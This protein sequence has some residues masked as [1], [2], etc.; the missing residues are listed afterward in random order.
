MLLCD[1]CDAGFHSSCVGL[2]CVPHGSW[3][4]PICLDEPDV[5]DLL[6]H[7]M[8]K[9]SSAAAVAPPLSSVASGSPPG[10][11]DGS[12]NL[13]PLYDGCFSSTSSGVTSPVAPVQQPSPPPSPSP[14][15]SPPLGPRIRN[16][17]E[18]FDPSAYTASTPDPDY[19]A[20]AAA[21]AAKRIA[22]FIVTDHDPSN[23][24]DALS[25]PD[26]DKWQAAMD[27]ELAS[28]L[29]NDT[30]TVTTLPPGAR[31]IPTKWVFAL[32]RGADG[33][34]QR[35][36]ARLVT[37]GFRQ[38]P[39]IDFNELYSP[40]AKSATLRVFL[41]YVAEHDFAL[42]TCDVKTAFLNANLDETIYVTP[43]PGYPEP[44]GTVC[45]LSKSLYGLRQSPRQWHLRL[46][47]ELASLGF[48]PASADASLFIRGSGKTLTFCLT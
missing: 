2:D 5:T 1:T 43:P 15:P 41:A 18:R 45:L 25:R 37:Q 35:Y 24:T 6:F 28:L 9:N 31:A 8:R 7:N 44:P 27:D 23:H 40:V 36:K 39:G 4:C 26:A 17:P 48:F 14:T 22:P 12:P 30:W 38:R 10:S 3:H 13:N 19:V 46:S 16:Q 47:E 34:I 33:S 20:A 42:N 11:V 29:A 21:A 32:K